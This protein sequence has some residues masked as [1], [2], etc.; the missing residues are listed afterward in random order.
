MTKAWAILRGEY[1]IEETGS[2]EM[3]QQSIIDRWNKS[4]EKRPLPYWMAEVFQHLKQHG[5]VL[6]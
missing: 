4:Y 5:K 1:V 6:S 2:L 3:A